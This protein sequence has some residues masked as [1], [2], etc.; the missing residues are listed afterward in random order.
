LIS[1]LVC[2]KIVSHFSLG[3]VNGLDVLHDENVVIGGSDDVVIAHNIAAG[4]MLW[5]KDLHG[6]VWSLCIHENVVVV[7]V[8]GSETLVLDIASGKQIHTIPSAGEEVF[9]ICVFDGEFSEVYISFYF[10]DHVAF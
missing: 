6:M 7:P 10:F 3:Y 9:G 2:T 8:D 4:V 5:R 1:I